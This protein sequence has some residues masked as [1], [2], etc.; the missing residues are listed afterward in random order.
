MRLK[1][2]YITRLNHFMGM[3]C[4]TPPPSKREMVL[5]AIG[6]A[7]VARNRFA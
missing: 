2:R 3:L 4:P 5:T 1:D 7:V 6:V